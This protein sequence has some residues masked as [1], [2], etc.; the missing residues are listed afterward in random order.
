MAYYT[1]PAGGNR[2]V[3]SVEIEGKGWDLEA[4]AQDGGVL[5]VEVK[6]LSGSQ[7][8]VELT[9]NEYAKMRSDRERYV[10]YI[11]SSALEKARMAHIFRFDAEQSTR[12]NLIWEA[13]DGRTLAIEERV[14][15]RL[16]ADAPS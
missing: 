7:I 10:I 11:L 14:A 2:S 5:N 3:R 15:A 12:T 1:S 8:V 4:T 16:S 13:D 9:P 6:G